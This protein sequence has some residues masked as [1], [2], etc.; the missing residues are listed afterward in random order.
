MWKLKAK[1]A[2]PAPKAITRAP[3]GVSPEGTPIEIYTL[4]NTRGA[5]ACILTWGGI[6]TS[7]KVPDRKGE[8]GDVV[9]GYDD[10]G[11]YLKNQQYFGALIGRYGNRIANGTFTLNGKTITLPKNNGPNCLHGG[12]KGFDR[13]VWGAKTVEGKLGPALGLTYVSK[14]GEEGFPG[15]LKVTAVYTL[16]E[17]NGLRLD[18][19]ATT[20]QLTVC[21]LTHHSYFNL[22]GKGHVL[23]HQVHIDADAFTPVDA[24]LIPTGELRLVRD[25]P[26]DFTTPTP[27][28]ARIDQDDEQLKL[29]HGYDH[30]YVLNKTEGKLCLAARVYEPGSGRVM[31]LLTT[32]PGVQFYSGNFIGDVTG[33]GGAAYHNRSGFCLEPQ[34]FPDSP[35]RPEFPA[36]EMRP[37]QTFQSTILY[38]FSVK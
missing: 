5:E 21:N 30:N 6:V 12:L 32:E 4:R 10:L 3:F 29:G 7:L 15:T 25:T 18:F 37:G 38:R 9:L 23:D 35:N 24:D 33:K 31:E 28:G 14:D 16:T 20:D 17:D 22:A 34:H 8:F 11:S 13:V 2:K 27:L 36:T 19:F 26:L 1:A